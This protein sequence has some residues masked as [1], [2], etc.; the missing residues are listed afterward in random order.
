MKKSI[1][2]ILLIAC[3]VGIILLIPLFLSH[4]SPIPVEIVRLDVQQLAAQQEATAQV[5]KQVQ[6][7]ARIRRAYSCQEDSDCIIVDK[8]PCGCFSGPKGVT[9]INVNHIVDFNMANSQTSVMKSCP[10]IPS[11]EREC[12]PT[13]RAVCEAHTCKIIY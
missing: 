1:K 12:S 6:Q 5:E 3:T 10:E 8:D 7:Q 13:A 4:D 9:A 2:N 11:K